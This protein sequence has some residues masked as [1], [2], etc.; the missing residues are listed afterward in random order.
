MNES[1]TSDTDGKGRGRQNYHRS[2][3]IMGEEDDAV[4]Y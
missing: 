3:L 2:A 1:S 4:V